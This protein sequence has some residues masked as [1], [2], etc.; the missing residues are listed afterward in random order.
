MSGFMF[1]GL[2]EEEDDDR[3]V[4]R[5]CYVFN[6]ILEPMLDDGHCMHCR[7][8]LTLQCKY[9]HEFVDEDGEA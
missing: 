4:D 5:E 7:H 8:Y 1:E 9:I 2:S 6:K 3:F